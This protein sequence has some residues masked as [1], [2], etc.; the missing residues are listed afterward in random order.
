LPEY[1]QILENYS[2]LSAVQ[3]MGRGIEVIFF[4]FFL[5]TS[6][7]NSL[8]IEMFTSLDL[9]SISYLNLSEL[10]VVLIKCLCFATDYLTCQIVTII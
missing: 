3:E 6:Y 2:G 8:S 5:L 10:L 1:L 4:L 9:K 7:N